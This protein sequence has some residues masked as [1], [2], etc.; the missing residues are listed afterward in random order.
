MA[1]KYNTH[2]I[3]QRSI[4]E[5]KPFSLLGDPLDIHEWKHHSPNKQDKKG[6]K[7][8]FNILKNFQWEINLQMDQNWIEGS[9][10]MRFIF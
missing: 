5:Y 2:P 3:D 1:M 8:S 7:F 9:N 10:G 4:H 6:K